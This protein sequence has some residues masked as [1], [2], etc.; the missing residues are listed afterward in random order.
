M[1]ETVIYLPEIDE[2][3]T[4][5][6]DQVSSGIILTYSYRLA[7]DW[8]SNRYESLIDTHLEFIGFT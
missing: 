6:E 8:F 5:V 2:I 4:L 1:S 3:I 7:G